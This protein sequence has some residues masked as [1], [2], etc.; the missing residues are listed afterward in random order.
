MSK[1]VHGNKK[2]ATRAKHSGST[3]KQ[4]L[5]VRKYACV[6]PQARYTSL[7]LSFLKDKML[8]A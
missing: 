4:Q 5:Q 6:Q 7:R 2:A 3:G 1:R 8:G